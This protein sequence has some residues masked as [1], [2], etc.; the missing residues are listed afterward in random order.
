M[1]YFSNSSEGA[2]F[3]EQCSI[4]KYGEEPCPIFAVQML[5]NY[6]ACNNEVATK[7]LE[8]LVRQDGTCAMFETF[9]KDLYID[10]KNLKLF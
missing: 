5:Y 7:I 2:E 1:A 4:C 6:D 3:D 9:R 10:A 8:E